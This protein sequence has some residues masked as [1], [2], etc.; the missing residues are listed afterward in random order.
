LRLPHAALTTLRHKVA[1]RFVGPRRIPA[2]PKLTS[3][4]RIHG[5]RC[6]VTVSLHSPNA[7]THHCETCAKPAA[8]RRKS[9]VQAAV[10]RFPGTL[11][12]ATISAERPAPRSGHTNIEAP[13]AG[14]CKPVYHDA[15]A[16]LVARGC[17]DTKP[18]S[19][20]RIGGPLIAGIL[21]WA[22][23]DKIGARWIC[24]KVSGAPIMPPSDVGSVW[25]LAE[26]GHQTR[27][28]QCSKQSQRQPT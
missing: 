24:M 7:Q 19:F 21:N 13:E 16:G 23:S 22:A 17:R 6:L 9:E 15:S 10:L 2:S 20:T 12:I 4:P 25:P 5:R 27:L 3:R 1:L 18:P 14:A 11:G 26:K 8:P 28:M